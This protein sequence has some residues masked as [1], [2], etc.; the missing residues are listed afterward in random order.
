MKRLLLAICGVLIAVTVLA[1]A[2]RAPQ[3]IYDATAVAITGG[4]I[5]GVTN[6]F[7]TVEKSADTVALSVAECSDTLITNRGWDGNDDQTFTLPDAD[8]VVGAELK[9]VLLPAVT[10]ADNDFYLDC[11]GST[12]Q[13]YID[14]AAV[15]DGE[16]LWLDNPTIGESLECYTATLDGT[17]YDWFC[18]N[19]GVAAAWADKGS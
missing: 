9:F 18:I 15:G 14:G 19:R 1:H 12:T 11:E 6:K 3:T 16:R 10:D 2:P 4:T 8:T 5:E 7:T 13:F 17:T